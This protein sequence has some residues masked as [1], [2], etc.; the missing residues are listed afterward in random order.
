MKRVLAGSMLVAAAA[1]VA[2]TARAEDAM[3]T[4]LDAVGADL[5]DAFSGT[6]LFFYG[7]AVA[8]TGAMA[9]GGADQALRVDVQEHLAAPA[10][11]TASSYAGYLVPALA[12]PGIY[13]VGALAHD[14]VMAGAGSAAVQA[15]GVALVTMTLL[16]VGTGREYPLGGG[17]PSAPDRLDHP[18]E[19][20][21][22]TPVQTLWPLP[23][24]PSGHTLGTMSVAAALWGFFPDKAWIPVVG[25]SLALGIGFGMVVGD[26]HWAS[27]VVA[28]ALIGHAIG[29]AIG[30]SFR[31]RVGGEAGAADGLHLVPALGPGTAGVG[32]LGSW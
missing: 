14:R 21:T 3:P 19:A 25:Y 18:D 27:D 6:N 9:F 11:A 1:L 8:A 30:R 22:F 17:S 15:L 29:Y 32:V 13:L 10:Y 28:G 26:A 12:A 23:A 31:R 4:P 2:T 7:A 5:A 16:K 24:W 20:H